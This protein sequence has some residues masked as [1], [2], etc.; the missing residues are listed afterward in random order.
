VRKVLAI[1][2]RSALPPA[3]CLC[4]LSFAAL[5]LSTPTACFAQDSGQDEIDRKKDELEQLRKELEERRA[6]AK[7]LEGKERGVQAQ[8]REIDGSLGLTERYIKKLE[9]REAQVLDELSEL[10][11][12]LTDASGTLEQRKV[13]LAKRLRAMYKRGRYRSLA[14]IV[15]S[16]SFADV[17]SHVRFLHLVAKRDKQIMSS[18]EVYQSKVRSTQIDLENN[19]AEIDRIQKEKESEKQ[20]LAT[21]KKKRQSTMASIKSEKEAHLAEAKKL[22]EAAGRIKALIEALEAARAA[23]GEALPQ[24]ATDLA[25]AAG[26]VPWPVSGEVVTRF[27]ANVHPRFG[28]KTFS[29]GI[30]IR[31]S[32]GTPIRCV[33][34]GKV[35]FVDMLPGYDRCIIVN[36]GRGYYT[37][38]AHCAGAL[39]APGQ[40][41]KGG[42]VIASV[43]DGSALKGHVLHF[44]IRKGKEALDPLGWLVKR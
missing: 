39:V 6:K 31:V 24:W 34:D 41:I 36:H 44:E 19:K 7:E 8:I 16:S 23:E 30:D 38:Y 32:S 21:L 10:E 1:A 17:M 20:H 4:I 43:G 15:S 26:R 3:L 11:V 27:G 18:I 12:R 28:T 22:E 5:P 2:A 42:D 37:L 35:E 9:Q 33:A 29:N 25:S 13:L 14:A 40:E